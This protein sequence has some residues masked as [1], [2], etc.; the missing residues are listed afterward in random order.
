M[1][2]QIHPASLVTE[3]K[4]GISGKEMPP[5]S[6]ELENSFGDVGYSGPQPPGGTGDHPYVCM[7]YGL[8]VDKLG[9]SAETSL[10]AFKK[11]LKGKILAE[12]ATTGTYGR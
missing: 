6:K 9:L 10:S 5:G 8:S 12:A 11:A 1:E 3:L 4:E 2:A 7:V